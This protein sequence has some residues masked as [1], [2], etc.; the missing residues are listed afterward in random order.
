MAR[1]RKEPL[2]KGTLADWTALEQSGR[3]PPPPGRDKAVSVTMARTAAKE[4]AKPTKS[5]K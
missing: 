1:H 3:L 4:A 5:D 2:L